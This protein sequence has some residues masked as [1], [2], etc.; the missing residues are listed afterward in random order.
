MHPFGIWPKPGAMAL[1]RGTG[2]LSQVIE[3][4][5]E[6]AHAR[7]RAHPASAAAEVG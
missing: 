5:R 2:L 7:L 1:M 6:P 3:H 4:G